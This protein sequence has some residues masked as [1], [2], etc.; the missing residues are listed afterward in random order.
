MK[1]PQNKITDATLR[2]FGISVG[3]VFALIALYPVLKE[4]AITVWAIIIAAALIFPAIIFPGLL[5][6]P[7]RFWSMIGSGLGWLNTR[8]ILSVLYFLAIVPVS[9][10]MRIVDSD[11]LKLKFDASAHS[12]REPPEDLNGSNLTDQH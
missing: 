7:F 10:F 12:Y 5:I 6:L 4:E 3:T 1:T 8:I 9:L 2:S 11:P